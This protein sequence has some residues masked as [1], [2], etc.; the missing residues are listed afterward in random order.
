ME[1][2]GLSIEKQNTEDK[3]NKM[4]SDHTESERAVQFQISFQSRI[5]LH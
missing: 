2:N 3:G 5:V 1:D 4:S